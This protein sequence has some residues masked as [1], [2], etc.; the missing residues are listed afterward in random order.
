MFFR[1]VNSGLGF[2]HPIILKIAALQ[3][4]FGSIFCVFCMAGLYKG[5]SQPYSILGFWFL[6]KKYIVLFSLYRPSLHWRAPLHVSIACIS[7]T[8]TKKHLL[9]TNHF[10]QKD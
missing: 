7:F 8:N 9:S 4:V 2:G 10:I 3:L 5:Q 6:C 1:M